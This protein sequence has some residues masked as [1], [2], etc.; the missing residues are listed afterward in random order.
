[1]RGQ[2]LTDRRTSEDIALCSSFHLSKESCSRSV[3]DKDGT[4]VNSFD[5]SSTSFDGD[6]AINADLSDEVWTVS[7]RFHFLWFEI[8]DQYVVADSIVFVMDRLC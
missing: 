6:G 2:T 3:S 7:T 4:Y 8:K 1:M 5:G